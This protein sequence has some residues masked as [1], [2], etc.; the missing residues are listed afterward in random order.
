MAVVL[1]QSANNKPTIFVQI[2]VSR[3]LS[4]IL[5]DEANLRRIFVLGSCLRNVE[6]YRQCS[7]ADIIYNT[8]LLIIINIK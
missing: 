8:S 2:R 7:R 4:H 1:S 3:N 5:K 6:V